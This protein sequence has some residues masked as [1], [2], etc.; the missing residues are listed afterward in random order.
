MPRIPVEEEVTEDNTQSQP[1]VTENDRT[2][3]HEV[4]NEAPANSGGEVYVSQRKRARPATFVVIILI[5]GL[6]GAC[7]FLYNERQD[8]RAQVA[9]LSARPPS[10]EDEAADLKREVGAYIQLPD[11]ELPT[12]ATVVDVNKVKDQAF[13]AKSENGD[14][15]LIFVKSGK[16]ILYRPST[17]KI[18]EIAPINLN[19]EQTNTTPSN[20]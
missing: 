15:V 14:K 9:E 8:L 6:L 2:F 7:V 1:E 19:Q 17:K 5:L 18:I 10:S 3:D 20:R 16:A 13:F 4:A 12:I 11:N